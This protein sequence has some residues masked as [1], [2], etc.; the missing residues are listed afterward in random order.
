[1]TLGDE[2]RFC[3]GTGSEPTLPA[4][5]VYSGREVAVESSVKDCI[6]AGDECSDGMSD[7]RHFGPTRVA[8]F[9]S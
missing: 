3:A 1:M 5:D 6:V 8:S 2:E 9:M 7:M 4:G